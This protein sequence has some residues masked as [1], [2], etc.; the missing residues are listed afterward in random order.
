[1]ALKSDLQASPVQAV[2]EQIKYCKV[3]NLVILT[4]HGAIPEV[5]PR[6]WTTIFTMPDG[7]QPLLEIYSAVAFGASA[8]KI[9][10]IK[11]MTNG[12]V[13]A[14]CSQTQ[15][16]NSAWFSVVFPVA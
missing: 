14:F 8:D 5:T 2:L 1:M 7:Y 6:E 3:G 15:D 4:S 16:K 13:Q 9:G 12:T 11:I 10:A